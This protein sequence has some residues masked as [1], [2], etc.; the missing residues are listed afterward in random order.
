MRIEGQRKILEESSEA[1]S[2]AIALKMVALT[3]QIDARCKRQKLAVDSTEKGIL[4]I[5]EA[6]KKIAFDEAQQ[7]LLPPEEPAAPPARKR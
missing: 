6:L 1:L 2:N 7:S 3:F 4:E 5:E